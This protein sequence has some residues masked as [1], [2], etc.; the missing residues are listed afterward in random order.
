MCKLHARTLLSKNV[1]ETPE[2]RNQR[3]QVFIYKS[4]FIPP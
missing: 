2:I 1:Q 4:T 3:F